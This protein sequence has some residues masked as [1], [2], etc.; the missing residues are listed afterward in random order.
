MTTGDK[1]FFSRVVETKAQPGW[2]AVA[3]RMAREG[4]GT[5]QSR[6]VVVAVLL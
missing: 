1:N 4:N 5:S 3:E 6:Q 2:V